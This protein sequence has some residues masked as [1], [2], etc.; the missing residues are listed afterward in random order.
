MLKEITHQLEP[1]ADLAD[2]TLIYPSPQ[3]SGKH[4]IASYFS[5]PNSDIKLHVHENRGYPMDYGQDF[6]RTYQIDLIGGHI[7]L[8][9]GET[10][11]RMFIV[12]K[13]GDGQFYVVCGDLMEVSEVGRDN[14]RDRL[15]ES[16][17]KYVS[18][19]AVKSKG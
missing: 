15:L 4:V 8:R 6:D 17:K 10:I 18:L 7:K 5:L 12:P 1:V 2:A 16:I 13:Q 19:H 9:T 14:S 3:Y 11:S